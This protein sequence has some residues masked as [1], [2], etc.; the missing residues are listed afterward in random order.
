MQNFEPLVS[1]IIPTYNR[2]RFLPQAIQ[3][4]LDQTLQD[5]EIIV[6]DDGSTDNTKAILEDYKASVV[7]VHTEHRGVSH[8][9]NTGMRVARVN[10]SAFSTPMI[11]IC[12][13]SSSSSSH[14]SR[15]IRTSA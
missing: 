3:S 8:A 5:L 11:P 14:S 9:R 2:A 1:V 15:R 10:I 13:I 7:C 6:V 12:L 4:V